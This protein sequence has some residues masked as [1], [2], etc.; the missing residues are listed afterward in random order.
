VTTLTFHRVSFGYHAGPRDLFDNLQFSLSNGWTG[1]VG[2]NGSGKTTLL[3][4]ACGDLEPREGSIHVPTSAVYCPQRTDE[5]PPLLGELLSASD[6]TAFRWRGVLGVE[7]DA[8]AR[9][10]TL[11]HGERK[12]A[13]LAAALW[14]EPELLAVDEPTNHLDAPARRRVIDALRAFRGVGLLVSHDRELLDGLCSRCLFLLPPDVLLRSGGYSVAR[15]EL[16]QESALASEARNQ[17]RCDRKHLEREVTQ[18]REQEGKA[19]RGRSK[20]RVDRRDHDAKE[21]IDRARQSD[22][23]AGKRQRQ[24]AGRLKQAE[25]A[26]RSIELRSRRATGIGIQGQASSRNALIRLVA[27]SLP[28]GECR[29]LVFPDLLMQPTDRIAL[30]GPNG[31]GKS[32]L[33]R[34]IM[35]TST[36]ESHRLI[37]VPQ[38]IT[39]DESIAI[40]KAARSATGDRL[41]ET[42]NWVSRLG[43]DPRRVLDTV[44]PSPGEVRK[45]LL[46]MKLTEHPHLIV[47]DEPT[48]HMDLPS[49]ECLEEALADCSCGLLLVSH[50]TRFLNRLTTTRWSIEP[51][52]RADGDYR[53]RIRLG[54]ADAA[55]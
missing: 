41:G 22:S 11:S 38:E 44:L 23:G 43:S 30:I 8:L 3:Q 32:T 12:R 13:Q 46:A 40:H 5:P 47:M 2:A 1:V 52:D 34:H 49:I 31:S 27:G 39:A 53:L 15:Q 9:W 19:D 26:E 37:Y 24:L 28:L 36:L 6:A 10:P 50:D 4:L 51:C 21:K 14:R 54:Q 16:D 7:D 45:L 55:E 48:N 35:E 29:K 25:Q 18:R 33:V 42:M 17:A 20:R